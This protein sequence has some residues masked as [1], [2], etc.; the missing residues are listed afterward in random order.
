MDKSRKAA[1]RALTN[2]S[3]SDDDNDTLKEESDEET[4]SAMISKLAKKKRESQSNQKATTANDH[5]YV[6]SN[7][8]IVNFGRKVMNYFRI[9]PR[10]TFLLGSLDKEVPVVQ[11]KPRQARKVNEQN[12]EEVRTKIKEMDTNSEENESSSTVKE[13]E[14]IYRILERKVNKQG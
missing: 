14:R 9:P 6:L 2:E 1:N 5:G 11:R 4:A 12:I 8:I 10:P 13:I 7:T 3:D